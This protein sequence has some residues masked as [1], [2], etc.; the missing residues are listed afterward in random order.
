MKRYFALIAALLLVPAVQAATLT[1]YV[2]GATA[3]AEDVNANEAAL[4]AETT[5]NTAAVAV[6]VA[7]A[8]TNATGISGNATGIA[9]NTANIASNSTAIAGLAGGG[10]AVPVTRVLTVDCAADV[11][12]DSIDGAAVGKVQVNLTGPCTE[13][14]VIDR[15]VEIIAPV[16]TPAI[17]NGHVTISGHGRLRL[18][19]IEVSASGGADAAP[20]IINSTVAVMGGALEMVESRITHTEDGDMNTFEV[21][22]FTSANASVSLRGAIITSTSATEDEASALLL[23]GGTSLG[24]W[25]GTNTITGTGVQ[26]G[27]A[28]DCFSGGTIFGLGGTNT[29]TGVGMDEA[30][31]LLLEGGCH[32]DIFLGTMVITGDV[33]VGEASSLSL[34][35]TTI[36]GRLDLFDNSTLDL[37]DEDGPITVNGGCDPAQPFNCHRVDSNSTFQASTDGG[38]G[39]SITGAFNVSTNSSFSLRGNAA[40]TGDLQAFQLS[41]ISIGAFD[42]GESTTVTGD[43]EVGGLS[44]FQGNGAYTVSGDVSCFGTSESFVRPASVAG[45]LVANGQMVVDPTD[46]AT[47]GCHNID[48]SP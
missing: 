20:G 7:A 4:N 19:N 28:L 25:S 35:N 26:E 31:G 17:I 23:T 5:A 21:G 2:P 13:N 8:A 11:L 41:S 43:I 9:T 38:A 16:A 3:T 15:E 36:N 12:Q 10:D 45:N 39:I 37:D 27:I 22:V 33:E 48:M 34:S 46:P 32:G 29:L 42:V 6:N 47:T 44:S 30:T 14:L 40:L 1:P 18:V 24:F